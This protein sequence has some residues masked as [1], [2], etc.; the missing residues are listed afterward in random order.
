MSKPVKNLVTKQYA[1]AIGD[2][3]GAVVI[4]IRGIEANQNNELRG[5]LNEKGIKITVVKNSL[6]KRA[7][8]GT[9][10]EPIGE[11]LT[12]A[13][14]FVYPT[15]EDVSVVNVARELIEQAKT[16][17]K[18]E[19]KGALLEGIVFQPDQIEALSKYPTREEAQAQVVQL[20]LSPAQNLVGAILGPGRKIASIVKAVE[21][22]LENGEEIKKAG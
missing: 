17:E 18:L 10:L 19:F 11:L 14:A 16:L 21:E 7:I 5:A 6:A 12:G 15:G 9:T 13:C 1:E 8:S 20:I 3:S 22:K 2:V 4:D